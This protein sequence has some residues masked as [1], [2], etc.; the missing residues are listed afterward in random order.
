M[1]THDTRSASNYVQRISEVVRE[2]YE[3]SPYP[4]VAQAPNRQ[5]YQALH[6][7]L[8]LV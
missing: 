4:V 1:T 8:N 2:F 3:R 5:R 6:T 7:Q